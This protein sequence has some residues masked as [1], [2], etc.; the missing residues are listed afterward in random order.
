MIPL[1]L[2]TSAIGGAVGIAAGF[3]LAW[4]L[5]AHTIT[6]IH[7][8]TV[9]ERISIQ[10]ANRTA[11]E[12]LMQRIQSAQANAT[13]RVVNL[14]T[15]VD[16]TRDVG[17]GLRVK[18]ADTVRSAASDPAACSD[19]AA[20]LGAIFDNAV[21]ELTSLAA[22]ADRHASDVQMMQEAWPK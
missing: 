9:N 2:I 8:D 18:T 21:T 1:S 12:G 4:Q 16:R 7:L 20:A 11:T 3:G 5:Q 10:R 15:A 22:I 14:R 17:L 6:Q 19:A 13:A